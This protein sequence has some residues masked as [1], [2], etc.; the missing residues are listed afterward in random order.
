MVIL[1]GRL[2]HIQTLLGS[3]LG[4]GETPITCIHAAELVGK[5]A[6]TWDSDIVVFH[7]ELLDD[8]PVHSNHEVYYCTT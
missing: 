1:D 8:N 6:V 2:K 5:I 7:P 4:Y 3:D